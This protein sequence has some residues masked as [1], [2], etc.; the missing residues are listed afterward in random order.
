MM[1]EAWKIARKFVDARAAAASIAATLAD[2]LRGR[3]AKS[4]RHR[5]R[6]RRP[7]RT[8]RARYPC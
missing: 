6:E 4:R 7:R 1:T 5:I 3:R 2:E 8:A